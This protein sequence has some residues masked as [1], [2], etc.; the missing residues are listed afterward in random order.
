MAEIIDLLDNQS[1]PGQQKK[2]CGVITDRGPCNLFP[3]K[4]A[5]DHKCLFHSKDPKVQA[6]LI[7]GRKKGQSLPK[8]REALSLRNTGLNYIR[9]VNDLIKWLNFLNRQYFKRNI[10]A[11]DVSVFLQIAGGLSKLFEIRDIQT[12]IL[13]IK[14]ILSEIQRQEPQEEDG[15]QILETH[16]EEEEL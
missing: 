3:V 2:R 15:S 7:E 1:T 5:S 8:R 16:F 12:E 4:I 14:D 10:N 6:L 11:E 13:E 9:N